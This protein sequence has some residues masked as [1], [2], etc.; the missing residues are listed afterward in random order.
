MPNSRAEAS[1]GDVLLQTPV[2]LR[3]LLLFGFTRLVCVSGRSLA[4]LT[5][6][7]LF[8]RL[9]EEGQDSPPQLRFHFLSSFH[10]NYV[11]LF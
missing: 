2:K 4:D 8:A 5:C 9:M 7:R 6:L 3:F 11:N 10:C 1:E